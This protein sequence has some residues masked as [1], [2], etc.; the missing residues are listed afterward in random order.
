MHFRILH[1][2]RYIPTSTTVFISFIS[3]WI[4]LKSLPAR[5]TLGMSSLLALT[6]QYGN[7]ARSL[8][9]VG[10]VKGADVYFVTI[11]LFIC[12]TML[13]VAFVWQAST[14]V[15]SSTQVF[16]YI[17]KI[18]AHVR[19]KKEIEKKSKRL[20]QLKKFHKFQEFN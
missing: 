8:P 18:N 3:F 12:G 20:A 2:N 9:K 7:I 13:E 15:Y 1:K 16:S 14:K 10:Y 11:T 17:E 6:Y 5:I 4:D 19:Q